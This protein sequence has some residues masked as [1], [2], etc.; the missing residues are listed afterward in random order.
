MTDWPFAD[1][2]NLATFTVR[3]FID[4]QK[5]ILFVSHD[6]ADGCWQFLTGDAISMDDAMLVALKEIVKRDPTVV[7]LADLPLGWEAWR[8]SPES[9]WVRQNTL[10]ES[11][12][13]A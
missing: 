1:P 12:G 9:Q 13:V 7:A 5:P 2:P 11:G 3:Q 10:P 6:A 4:G 8:E